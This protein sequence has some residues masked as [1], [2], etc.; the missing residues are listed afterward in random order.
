MQIHIATPADID[1][2][3]KLLAILFSQEAEFE[4]DAAAQQQGLATI[5]G[6][7]DI[8]KILL[9]RDGNGIAVGMVN[10]LFTVSTALGERV[11]LLEDMVVT[12]EARGAGAGSQLMKQ[13]VD[14]ARAAGCRRITVLSDRD[15][16]AAHRFYQ[17]H[18][19]ALSAMIPLRLA[20]DE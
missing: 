3:C 12:R 4:V 20:L 14:T 5:I 2:L 16:H 18:G 7:P 15:N 13:A 17:R 8:G 1:D 9:A 11:A 6:N 19:F 10:L